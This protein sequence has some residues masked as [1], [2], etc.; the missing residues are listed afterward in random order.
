M[1][2]STSFA[3]Q[4]T[5]LAHFLLEQQIMTSYFLLLFVSIEDTQPSRILA[6]AT[7]SSKDENNS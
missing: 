7:L 2:T 3:P 4:R 1:P 6:T 5:I